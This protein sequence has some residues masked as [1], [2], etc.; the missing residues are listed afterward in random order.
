MSR[1]ILGISLFACYLHPSA[2]KASFTNRHKL[3]GL[4]TSIKHPLYWITFPGCSLKLLFFLLIKGLYLFI[5]INIWELIGFFFPSQILRALEIPDSGTSLK[6][7]LLLFKQI[8]VGREPR[9]LSLDSSQSF[10]L[11]PS[12]ASLLEP[13]QP[14]RQELTKLLSHVP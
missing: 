12:A 2:F 8:S 4:C 13:I 3:T 7:H 9:N 14:S 5:E 6:I 10:W 11:Q 1:G